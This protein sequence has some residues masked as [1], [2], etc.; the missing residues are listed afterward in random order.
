M[1]VTPFGSP[2]R[3]EHYILRMVFGV[4]LVNSGRACGQG[5]ILWCGNFHLSAKKFTQDHLLK[6][7][8]LVANVTPAG[9]PDRAEHDILVMILVFFLANPCR[10]YLWSGEPLRDVGIQP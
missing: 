7:R 10:K 8:W 1:Y 3:A 4:L 2:D 9:S 6:T 5:A